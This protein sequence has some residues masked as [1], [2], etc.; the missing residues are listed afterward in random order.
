[1]KHRARRAAV[2][3]GLVMVVFVGVLATRTPAAN[4][5][6]G[7]PLL[8]R[9][10]PEIDAPTLAG[11]RLRLSSLRGTYVL[12]NFFNSWCVPCRQEHPELLKFSQ[13]HQAARDAVLVGVVHDDTAEA[14][15]SYMARDGGDWPVV[16]DPGRIGLD[17]G[18]R[19]Q[20]ETFVIDPDG[21]VIS[22]IVSAVDADGLDRLLRR[23]REQRA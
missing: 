6:A 21:V 18:V 19:G 17:F 3:V 4:V 16:D 9:P 8:G 10:A 23:A 13:R 22:R 15:R 5:V 2:G 11:G 14:V 1:V 20:P 12:V 7:S